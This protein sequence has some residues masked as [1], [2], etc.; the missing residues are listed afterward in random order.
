ML[1][2][3]ALLLLSEIL[4]FDKMNKVLDAGCGI[5]RNSIYFAKKGCNVYAVD[6]SEVALNQLQSAAV[7]AGIR[8]KI[9]ACRC[10]LEAPLP[11]RTNH[12]DLVIDSYVFCHFIDDDLKKRY[13][14]ELFRVVKPGAFVFMSLFSA[15]D[16]YYRAMTAKEVKDRTI[17]V[18]PHNG[19]AKQLYTESQ[20]KR[21]FSETFDVHY[22]LKFEFDD[23][24]LKQCYTR[25]LLILL[26][27]KRS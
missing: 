8:S 3:K 23:V 22:Y 19:I 13:R 18:D 21:F 20:F 7:K 10:S 27:R 16:S 25:S 1:P 9:C 24:V 6:F 14:E 2:S 4:E 26:L 17:V 5:G 12:F 11:F 15:E